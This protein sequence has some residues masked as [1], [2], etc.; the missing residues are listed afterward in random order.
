M[1]RLLTLAICILGISQSAFSQNYKND[2]FPDGSAITPWFKDYTKLQ[3]KDLGK[4]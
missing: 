1:K 4:Q 3:L 2:T